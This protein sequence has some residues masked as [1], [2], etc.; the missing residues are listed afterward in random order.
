MRQFERYPIRA[1]V[2]FEILDQKNKGEGFLRDVSLSSGFIEC[3]R[4]IPLYSWLRVKIAPK[5]R[6]EIQTM[7]HVL[8]LDGGGFALHFNW[9]DRDH[10]SNFGDFLKN[11]VSD[12]PWKTLTA[13]NDGQGVSP[14]DENRQVLGTQDPMDLLYRKSWASFIE[15]APSHYLEMMINWSRETFLSKNSEMDPDLTDGAAF[16][17]RSPLIQEVMKKVRTFAPTSL[18]ILLVGETGSGKEIFSRCIH[19]YGSSKDGPFIPVNC[20]AIPEHLAES[21]LF[22]HEKGSFSGAHQT[23]KGYMEAASGGT[24]LLDEIG[25]LPLMLQVKLL[26]VLQERTFS[27]VGSH[28]E[29]SLQCRVVSATNKNLKEAVRNGTFRQDLY[30]RL[31]GVMINIPPLRERKEDLPLMAE[32]LVKDISNKMGLISKPLSAEA[33]QAILKA[34]WTGN[35]RELY[36]S[37]SRAVIISESHEITSRDLGLAEEVVEKRAFPRTLREFR[38]SHE[39]NILWDCLVRNDGNVAKVSEE[40]DIS[41]PSV[42]NMLKKYQFN[43]GL[44]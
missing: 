30:Y 4:N 37:I 34:P 33:R 23:Q 38:E 44:F 24:I 7:G 5:D 19:Q 43:P 26:R 13:R 28:K 3:P 14:F 22:G 10:L 11:H 1:G 32:F 35:V 2:S 20:G 39:K 21:L 16:I 36:N 12:F 40:L 17:G 25:D 27:R 18:P 41:R 29:I 6:P 9:L 8:R 15:N 31:E 42:Y